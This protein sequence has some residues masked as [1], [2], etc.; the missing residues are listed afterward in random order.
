[1]IPISHPIVLVHHVSVYS[2]RTQS[3]VSYVFII[4][5]VIIKFVIQTRTF[6]ESINHGKATDKAGCLRLLSRFWFALKWFLRI[7]SKKNMVDEWGGKTVVREKPSKNTMSSQVPQKWGYQIKYNTTS[8]TGF[9]VEQKLIIWYKYVQN[10]AR[11]ILK[12]KTISSW[13]TCIFICYIWQIYLRGLWKEKKYGSHLT[14]PGNKGAII[15][16][17]LHPSV[18]KCSSR[19]I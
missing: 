10:I 14:G 7:Y 19:W 17:P 18:S 13:T 12:L 15:F 2:L 3:S 1:M 6:W 9:Q 8:Y 4:V 11:N 5:W 16:K